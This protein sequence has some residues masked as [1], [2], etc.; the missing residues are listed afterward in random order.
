MGDPDQEPQLN[1]INKIICK[2]FY[3]N[4]NSITRN[5]NWHL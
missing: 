2:Q 1:T 3:G 5:D 4:Y